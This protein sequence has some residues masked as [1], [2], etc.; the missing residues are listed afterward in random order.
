M[1]GYSIELFK[2]MRVDED[3]NKRDTLV[4]TRKEIIP[5]IPGQQEHEK[6]LAYGEFDRIGIVRVEN[7]SRFRDVSGQART[8][9]GDRQTLLVY[10]IDADKDQ[11]VYQNGNFFI[12]SDKVLKQSNQL[13]LGITILQFKYSQKRDCNDMGKFLQDYQENIL[14]LVEEEGKGMK[15][16]VFG[17]LG[18]FGLTI[19]WLADQYVDVLN[20]VTKIRKVNFSESTGEENNSAFLSSYTIF[21]QNHWEN[22]DRTQK[23][24]DIQGTSILHITLK[25]GINSEILNN[26]REACH[27]NDE[28]EIYHSAGEYDVTAKVESKNAYFVF[29]K[30][31]ILYCESPFFKKYVLQ[32]S[33]QLCECMETEKDAYEETSENDEK[34]KDKENLV[35]SVSLIKDIQNNY[36]ELRKQFTEMFPNTAGMVDTLDL[37]YSDY[38]A[39]ISTASNEMWESN[40]SYQFL[41]ILECL[42]NFDK[43]IENIDMS[44]TKVLTIVND[45]LSGFERQISHIAESNN[46]ILGTPTCQF[47]YSGQNNLTMYAYL[48]FIKEILSS[49]YKNQVNSNQAE[50]VPLIVTDIVPIIQSDLFIDYDNKDDTRVIAINLPMMSLYSPVCYFPYLYHEIFHYVVPKDRYVRNKVLGCLIS[51]EILKSVILDI[52]LQKYKPDREERDLIET[53]VQEYIMFYIYS[54]IIE[55]Y[56]KYI[57]SSFVKLPKKSVYNVEISEEIKNANAYEKELFLHWLNWIN[58]EKRVQLNSNPLQL[59]FSYLLEKSTEIK[60]CLDIWAH[61]DEKCNKIKDYFK[62]LLDSLYGIA[63]NIDSDLQDAKFLEFTSLIGEDVMV[64][65]MTLVDGIKEAVADTAMVVFENM[66]FSEYLLQFTRI[67]K[68]LLLNYDDKN[69]IEIQDIVRIGMILDFLCKDRNDGGVHDGLISEAKESFIDMYCG[70]YYSSHKAE[71]EGFINKLL[72]EA[73][74]WFEY[75]KGCYSLYCTKYQLYLLL[76][77]EMQQ[78]L[79][80]P[81][82]NISSDDSTYWKDYARSLRDYGRFIRSN[83]PDMDETIWQEKKKIID[84]IIFDLNIKLI[85]KYQRQ[86]SFSDLSNERRFKV[87]EIN[88]E[89]YNYADAVMKKFILPSDIFVT[90]EKIVKEYVWKF[91]VDSVGSLG[92]VTAEIAEQLKNSSTRLLGYSEHP[93]WYRGHQS[94]QYQL[95]PS[96]MRKWKGYKEKVNNKTEATLVKMLRK[97]YEE[98]KYRVDGI[99][100][101]IE[102]TGYTDSDY[103]ALMQHYSVASNFLDWT[104]DALSAL[105][106]ALE[107][108]IDEKTAKTDS[109][110]ALYVFSPAIYNYAR[111]KMLLELRETDT[112]KSSIE[113]KI[114]EELCAGIPNLTVPY[115]KDRYEVFLLGNEKYGNFNSKPFLADEVKKRKFAYYMPLAIYTA[116]LNKRIQAQN[117]IFLA[118]N[119]YTPPDNNDEF[120]YMAL[121]NIQECYLQKFKKDEETCPFL[122]KITI[123]KNERKGI[124]AWVKAFGM[125]KERCYPE[126]V[127]IGERIM[128]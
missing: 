122:Y 27:I 126:L 100:E 110:A 90:N 12:N 16:S 68:D 112:S 51:M 13:F 72:N 89:I 111:S 1:A 47:R 61:N 10:E 23:V 93:I 95:V 58:A 39:K 94:D 41:K 84:K 57:E 49:V 81:E 80:V 82:S 66:E 30:K 6:F 92:T 102:R 106:F 87:D 46:L 116:K 9:V 65:A 55:N 103:I 63:D 43:N 11:V 77:R 54:F 32:T 4:N 14:K 115:N 128:K 19:F 109:D 119:I 22:E 15:C 59:F 91:K 108:F 44:M 64:D 45:L 113:E 69:G 24:A 17:T 28:K 26:I 7:F 101:I 21:A 35:P 86:K 38:I 56:D 88:A 96:I 67:K 33:L 42:I 120:T 117:G 36:T 40:F 60:N 2:Y 78:Q 83:S 50:I 114:L 124:A 29:Q 70:L 25:K 105:Y 97:E 125:S 123:E 48:G 79:L 118:Y 99:S 62:M 76:L 20:T 104:E 74:N 34:N 5:S 53:F 8:W 75:L 52:I 121:E 31:G 3:Q 73:E 107:G 18:S 127:N 85:Y 37:L 71:E 98:F